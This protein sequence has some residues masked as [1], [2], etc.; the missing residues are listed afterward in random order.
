M[1][2][3][4]QIIS[5]FP[6]FL[7][8]HQKSILREYLQYKLLEAIYSSHFAKSL[9]F[10]GGTSIHIVHGSTRFSEDLDFDNRGLSPSEFQNLSDFLQQQMQR[11]GFLVQKKVIIKNAFHIFISFIEILSEMALTPHR[12]E[13]LLIRIDAEPQNYDY[14]PNSVLLNKFD[15]FQ[16][17]NVVPP[18]LLLAQK[19]VAIFGRKRPMGRDYYDITFLFSNHTPDYQYLGK[20][21][22]IDDLK[23]LK[24]QLLEHCHS[25]RFHQLSQDVA[26]FLY[27]D[28]E[29]KRVT[30]FLEFV[31]NL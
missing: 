9:I 23:T 18:S 26:P 25:L 19:I 10:M 27:H 29:K 8:Y 28:H 17:I 7:H 15:V 31:E 14:R 11:E 22:G 20:K 16:K 12:N 21:L 24:I 3:L 5:Y 1:L 13:K 6:P 4:R 2:D 30:Q